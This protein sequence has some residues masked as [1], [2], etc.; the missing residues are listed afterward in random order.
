[1]LMIFCF[2]F[3]FKQKTAYEMRISDWSSDVCSSDLGRLEHRSARC[4]QLPGLG[5]A[6][7]DLAAPQPP[8]AA[9]HVEDPLEAVQLVGQRLGGPAVGERLLDR[10]QA[11]PGAGAEHGEEP[12]VGCVG[13]VELHDEARPR[14]A[15]DGA[16]TAAEAALTTDHAGEPRRESM[17]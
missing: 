4:H 15:R 2:F 7:V 13:R 9:E 10:E 14:S 11:A 3:F 6:Q 17:E 16:G 5:L 12:G 8:G 1:M